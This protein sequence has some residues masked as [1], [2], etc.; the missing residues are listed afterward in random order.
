ME[1]KRLRKRKHVALSSDLLK[2]FIKKNPEHKN[3]VTWA[4]Y[5]AIILAFNAIVIDKIKG[6]FDGVMLPFYVGRLTI[7]SMKP[8]VKPINKALT[9]AT[10][11][12]ISHS[13]IHSDGNMMRILFWNKFE[14]PKRVEFSQLWK[15]TMTQSY[16]RELSRHYRDEWHQYRQIRP[17]QIIIKNGNNR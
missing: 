9:K 16:R 10:G 2:D 1:I 7:V 8:I 11:R 12:K 15:F 4:D 5:R 14:A 13:N 3:S 6:A 17:R